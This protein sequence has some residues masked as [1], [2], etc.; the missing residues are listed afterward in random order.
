MAQAGR[1]NDGRV[2]RLLVPCSN[3]YHLSRQDAQA[4]LSAELEAFVRRDGLEGATLTRLASPPFSPPTSSSG[5]LVEFRL[6][7]AARAAA[8]QRRGAFGE[9]IADLRLIGMAP[10]VIVPDDDSTVELRPS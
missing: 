1:N 9:L 5:W 6:D 7:S 3:P 4:W 10:T 2:P 8:M